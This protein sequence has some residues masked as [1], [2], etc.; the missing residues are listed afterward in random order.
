[1]NRSK[2][3][4]NLRRRIYDAWNVLKATNVIEEV[5]DDKDKYYRVQVDYVDELLEIIKENE[6][7]S[8]VDDDG[9]GEPHL[10][11]PATSKRSRREAFGDAVP[12]SQPSESN[13]AGDS[14]EEE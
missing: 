3:E 7:E 8:N 5:P 13:Q 1:V 9:E 11:T 4:D 10:R 12:L 6:H 14:S 2:K